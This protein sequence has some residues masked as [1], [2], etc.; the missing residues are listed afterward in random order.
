[1]GHSGGS[2]PSTVSSTVE[3]PRGAASLSEP[4][5]R[6]VPP[7]STTTV[8][9]PLVVMGCSTLI[10]SVWGAARARQAAG[11]EQDQP[12]PVAVGRGSRWLR[13]PARGALD[14]P[15]PAARRR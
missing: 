12:Q 8:T 4:K 13:P 11:H 9:S 2:D 3:P 10:P 14:R 6:E 7:A 1:T 15:L 5:R